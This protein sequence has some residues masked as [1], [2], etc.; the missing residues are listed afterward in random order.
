MSP[1]DQEAN[2]A[3]APAASGK[4][5]SDSDQTQESQPDA[6]EEV[7]PAAKAPPMSA[8]ARQGRRGRTRAPTSQGMYTGAFAFPDSASLDISQLVSEKHAVAA[9]AGPR[10]AAAK[11]SAAAASKGAAASEEAGSA[12]HPGERDQGRGSVPAPAPAAARPAARSLPSGW[13]EKKKKADP[14]PDQAALASTGSPCSKMV[15]AAVV[16]TL[17]TLVPA[18]AMVPACLCCVMSLRL[19]IR[20][21]IIAVQQQ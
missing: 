21:V 18:S 4:Q 13:K 11:P 2:D 5:A 3:S 15:P 20:S 7:A 8:P 19:P 1:A 12:V 14:S 10:P 17:P 16:V 9:K 6:Q